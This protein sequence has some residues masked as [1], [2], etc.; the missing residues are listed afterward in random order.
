MV[1]VNRKFKFTVVVQQHAGGICILQYPT[2]G[3]VASLMDRDNDGDQSSSLCTM[4]RRTGLRKSGDATD[5][6]SKISHVIVSLL[7]LYI[8]IHSLFSEH[9]TAHTLYTSCKEVSYNLN[10]NRGE[11]KFG[12]FA[13]WQ[14]N[15]HK[16]QCNSRQDINRL[17][18]KWD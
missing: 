11:S 15:N 17:I 9:Y 3:A 2:R 10:L 1:I 5:H 4:N 6:G 8:Y 14:H 18:C 13:L 16:S 7:F 12:L